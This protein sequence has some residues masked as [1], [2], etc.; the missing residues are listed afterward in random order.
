VKRRALSKKDKAWAGKTN[1]KIGKQKRP[2]SEDF[3]LKRIV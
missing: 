3:D 2:K 1:N